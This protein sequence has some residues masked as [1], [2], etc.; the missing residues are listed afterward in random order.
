MGLSLAEQETV[1]TY[2]RESDKMN[3]YTADPVLL[4]R[5]M[6]LEAY[7]LMREHKRGGVT[8]AADF[9]ADKKLLTLRTMRTKR[10]LTEEQ[11]AALSERGKAIRAKQLGR[12]IDSVAE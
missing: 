1:I 5:L 9:E 4:R 3:I 11:R 7:K 10:E 2:D 12:R 6:K 8:I